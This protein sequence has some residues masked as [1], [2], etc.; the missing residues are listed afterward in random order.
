MLMQL[1][2]ALSAA[3]AVMDGP[4][5]TLRVRH[6]HAADDGQSWAKQCA[7]EADVARVSVQ[8]QHPSL[9]HNFHEFDAQATGKRVAVFLDYDGALRLLWLRHLLCSATMRAGT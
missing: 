4:T 5:S 6:S 8:A 9:L 7:G 3:T 1:P 2:T